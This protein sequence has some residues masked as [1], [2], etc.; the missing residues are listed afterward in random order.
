M[1]PVAATPDDWEFVP[2]KEVDAVRWVT[3]AEAARPPVLRPRPP[4]AEVVPAGGPHDDSRFPSMT[5]PL[6]LVRHAY[7]GDRKKW[8]GPDERRPLTGKGRREAAALVDVLAGFPVER[9]VSSWYVRCLET[10]VHLACDRRLPVEVD[11]ALAE[12]STPA[13]ILALA[14]RSAGTVAV[15]CTHGDVI[16]N[17]F[18][19]LQS[20]GRP[21]RSATTPPWPRARR[22][23]SRPTATASSPPG[24]CRNPDR[25]PTALPTTAS[26]HPGALSPR[27]PCRSRSPWP[28]PR[29]ARGRRRGRTPETPGRPSAPMP[30]AGGVESEQLRQRAAERHRRHPPVAKAARTRHDQDLPGRGEGDERQ[31]DVLPGPKQETERPA[32]SRPALGQLGQAWSVETTEQVVRRIGRGQPEQPDDEEEAQRRP[33]GGDRQVQGAGRQ[34]DEEERIG[35]EQV[36][37]QHGSRPPRPRSEPPTGGRATPW[38]SPGLPTAARQ[39]PPGQPMTPRCT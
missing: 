33:T 32:G 24:T 29:R 38:T 25:R 20:R 12:G 28:P 22:G 37:R 21:R 31:P 7:A 5:V 8:E 14:R 39:K 3:P 19:R 2:N 27:R 15:L 4:G 13:D 1:T 16:E 18:A 34:Q 9:I 35:H 26:N 6:L 30:P 36:R 17:L 11:P 23:C 10:V